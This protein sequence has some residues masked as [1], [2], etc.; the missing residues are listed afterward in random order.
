MG[1]E[2]MVLLILIE[3]KFLFV[4]ISPPLQKQFVIHKETVHLQIFVIAIQTTLEPFAQPR[5]FH[6]LVKTIQM[7]VFVEGTGFALKTII[8]NVI[9]ITLEV[10]VTS[11]PVMV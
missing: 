10:N 1:W 6:A 2:F 5:N 9:Q 7:G 8:V 3:A 11:H 4:I